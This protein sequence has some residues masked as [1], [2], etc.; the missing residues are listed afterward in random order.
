ME[1]GMDCEVSR[2]GNRRKRNKKHRGWSELVKQWTQKL[3]T[4]TER[5]KRTIAV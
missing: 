2:I 3:E 4:L 5:T 1:M